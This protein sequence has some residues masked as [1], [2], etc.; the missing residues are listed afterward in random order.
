MPFVVLG[1]LVAHQLERVAALDQGLPFGGEALQFD[2]LDLRAV[3]FALAAALRL[4]VVVELAL[5]PA[6]GNRS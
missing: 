3:L 5:D 6:G 2:R 1:G 4:L